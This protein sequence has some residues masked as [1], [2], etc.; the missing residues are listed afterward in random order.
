VVVVRLAILLTGWSWL[1]PLF[2]LAVNAVIVWG[3]WGLLRETSPSEAMKE[4][5][6]RDVDGGRGSARPYL[7]PG[8]AAIHDFHVWPMSTTETALTCH[9]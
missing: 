8:V 4:R 1:D 5:L 7:R 3:T 6:A 9:S 2:S